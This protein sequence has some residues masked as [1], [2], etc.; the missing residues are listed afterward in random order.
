MKLTNTIAAATLI[1][2]LGW[3]PMATA[4]GKGFKNLTV[5]KD[6][7]KTLKKGMKAMTKGLGVKC[8]ACHIKGKWHKDDVEAKEEARQFFKVVVG[9]QKNEAALKALVRVLKR[10]SVKNPALL[11]E[12]ISM[13]E[14][15]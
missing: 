13:L 6:N 11:W 10:D 4:K 1:A 2:G 7:G 12:G 3:A 15:K 14:R 9:A 8:T 5:L